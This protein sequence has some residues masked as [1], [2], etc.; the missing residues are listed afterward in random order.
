MDN[1]FTVKDG[2]GG[3]FLLFFEAIFHCVYF[4]LA[5]V[6]WW[7]ADK[8]GQAV[9]PPLFVVVMGCLKC[10]VPC[11]SWCVGSGSRCQTV[12]P[13][14][15]L[16]LV[17]FMIL[18]L[19]ANYWKGI[20]AGWGWRGGSLGFKKNGW[21]C[22]EQPRLDFGTSCLLLNKTIKRVYSQELAD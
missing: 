11:P 1:N 8:L 7:H 10:T 9:P 3:F 14:P 16:V 21:G 6:L 18:W 17:D 2:W 13:T 15:T 22:D 20:K 4:W 19:A 12:N 5:Y